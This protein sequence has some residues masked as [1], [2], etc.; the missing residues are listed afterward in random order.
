MIDNSPKGLSQDEKILAERIQQKWATSV[1][2]SQAEKESS[3][4]KESSAG[5]KKSGFVTRVRRGFGR[6]DF[7]RGPGKNQ[8]IL[9]KREII[10]WEA[11][12]HRQVWRKE[13]QHYY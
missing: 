11:S 5:E 3:G 6:A 9:F 1:K 13:L 2:N 7:P 8:K 10:G 4:E 12:S